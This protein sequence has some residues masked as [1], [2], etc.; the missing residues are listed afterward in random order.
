MRT[1]I[2]GVAT[3]GNP[4]HIPWT[5]EEVEVLK[6][7]YKTWPIDY[8]RLPGRTR[9]V[10]HTKA[11]RLGLAGRR[12]MENPYAHVTP[13]EWAYLAGIVDGE[14]SIGLYTTRT[15]SEGKTIRGVRRVLTIAN[16]D[17]NLLAWLRS[18]FPETNEYVQAPDLDFGRKVPVTHIRWTR[19]GA[20]RHLLLGILPYLIIK[21]EKAVRLL[22][23]I[24]TESQFRS[25]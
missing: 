9:P 18:T 20:L 11:Y 8:S 10:I 21:K 14:G 17:E 22:E 7:M 13:T 23:H 19:A 25:R 12:M 16:T 15:K 4:N 5:P 6:D 1:N 24:E 3:K 2:V